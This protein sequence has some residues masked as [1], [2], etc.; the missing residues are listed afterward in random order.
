VVCVSV[1]RY[2]C[3]L[4]ERER[5]E[6]RTRMREKECVCDVCRSFSV[7]ALWARDEARERDTHCVEHVRDTHCVE[8]VLVFF[9]L[10]LLL[11]SQLQLLRYAVVA[12]ATHCCRCG[13]TRLQMWRH[14]VA[15]VAVCCCSCCFTL[16]Q[17]LR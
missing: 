5:E 1:I 12:A 14:T 8:H 10:W 4:R 11:L 2:L 16:V 13:G 7:S 3:P 17:L 9:F 6:G 15:A